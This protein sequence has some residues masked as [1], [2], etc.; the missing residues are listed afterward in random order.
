MEDPDETIRRIFPGLSDNAYTQMYMDSNI[1]CLK[2]DNIHINL[3]YISGQIE[4]LNL[5]SEFTENVDILLELI[6]KRVFKSI[7][8]WGDV[9]KLIED[10]PNVQLEIVSLCGHIEFSEPPTKIKCNI[11][12]VNPISG[13]PKIFE[14]TCIVM[15]NCDIGILEQ[16]KYSLIIKDDTFTVTEHDF[17]KDKFLVFIGNYRS[18]KLLLYYS[19][20]PLTKGYYTPEE[21]IEISENYYRPI[22]RMVKSSNF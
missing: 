6:S 20:F 10:F 2:T 22:V 7:R 1:I 18:E 9:P 19:P 13:I 14:P 4:V 5:S 8:F 3:G 16:D 17:L 15:E 11:L 12:V 21:I